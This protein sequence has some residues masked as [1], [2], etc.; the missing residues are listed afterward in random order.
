VTRVSSE[1][2]T[3]PE[4]SAPIDFV[5]GDATGLL[6]P[7]HGEALRAGGAALL[8]ASFHIF[9]ALSST[10]RVTRITRWEKCPGGSTGQKFFLS[11][12]YES[13]E[14]D[15]HTHLFVKFSRNFS[16]PVRDDRGK[17]EMESEVRLATISRLPSFPIKVP[18]AY[19]ADYH[20]E[21][22]T[23]LIIT[24]EVAFGA[25]GIEPHRGKCL[26]HEL[27]DSLTYY[28]TIIQ[29]LARIAGTHRSG[30][31]SP[32]IAARF[33]YDPVAAAAI[34]PIPYDEKQM[35]DLM[36]Q[37]ADFAAQCPQLLPAEII[38]PAFIAKLQDEACRFL[39]HEGTIKRF[40]QSNS[41][42]IAL[43]H[44]NAQID[45]AWFWHDSSG[46]LQCG[47]MD[48]GQVNQMNVA[49]S[50][51]GCLSGAGQEIWDR[52]LEE[53]IVLFANEFHRHGGPRVGAP[54]L[55]LHLQLYI[56]MMGLSYFMA[57][58][59]RILASLPEAV[60]A[61]GPLDLVFRS[62][63]TARS[64]LHV[65]SVFLSLWQSHDFGAI[66]DRLLERLSSFATT[67]GG[68]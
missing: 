44:W 38:S 31:L 54:E 59:S 18:T 8:T 46:A 35:R 67:A 61:S 6:I 9:G 13:P 58:P 12:E 14:G 56:A 60:K 11:V 47:L 24:E 21:S 29:A 66:L 28:R 45:N 27:V 64:N 42:L 50:L 30:R 7:A 33:P 49:F 48:W 36:E 3:K 17:Y 10:N 37:F 51:W 55:R 40:L 23:G 65:L 22:K 52:H 32:D 68:R 63:E 53:L 41:D 2:P 57:S 4:A 43:C 62:S 34:Y 5:R 1:A 39:K 15:L 20:H 26:D 25:E 16:D 19:F